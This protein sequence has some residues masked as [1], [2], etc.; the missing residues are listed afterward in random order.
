MQ[1][2]PTVCVVGSLN[3]DL[4]IT[5]KKIPK[6]GETVIG[7]VF[8]TYPGGK[9]ANQAVAAA[10]LGANVT[11]IGAV[12]ADTFGDSLLENLSR[13]GINVEGI[14]KISDV[15]TG[16]ASIIMSDHDNRI[17]VA[18]GANAYV[19]LELVDQYQ[20]QIRHSDIVLVQLETPIESIVRTIEIANEYDVPVIVNPAP[21]QVLPDKILSGC[22]FLTPNE[23]ELEAMEQE[24]LSDSIREKIILTKGAE[25]V[26][27]FENGKS[28]VVKS[29]NVKVADTT[30]AGDTFNGALAARLGGGA[31]LADAVYYANA[32]AALSVTK[33]GAQSGMPTDEE[34][35][36]FIENNE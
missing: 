10:R 29:H 23:I 13:E 18:S 28:K 15:A 5:T 32:A 12:G 35:K 7:E 4:T 31:S 24:S 22:T 8:E 11:M 33:L 16:V 26:Q 2:I 3:M 25:G 20:E 17:I 14:S 6:Q 9:G 36:R 19:T 27:F 34:V 1:K 30:G 21:Y